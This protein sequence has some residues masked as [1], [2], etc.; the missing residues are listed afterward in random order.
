MAMDNDD[1][2]TE[3]ALEFLYNTA[4]KF[5]AEV[6][7]MSSTFHFKDDPKN[8]VPEQENLKVQ[9]SSVIVE[10]VFLSQDIGERIQRFGK[11]GIRVPAWRKF[12]RRDLLINNGIKFQEG[13]KSGHDMTWTIQVICFANRYLRISEPLYI[14]RRRPDSVCHTKHTIADGLKHHGYSALLKNRD[15]QNTGW[16][17]CSWR[18]W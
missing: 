8:P 12:V 4:E 17:T 16:P 1:L 10:P 11:G 13:V 15:Q 9:M 3:H 6:V 2:L 7:H 5:N 18:K 14:Y